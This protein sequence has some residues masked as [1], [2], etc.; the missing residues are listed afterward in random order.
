MREVGGLL[1]EFVVMGI[2]KG[3][4][5]CSKKLIALNFLGNF[6]IE[7]YLSVICVRGFSG[8]AG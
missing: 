6:N 8:M 5:L 4:S 7:K 2:R 3:E 1:E